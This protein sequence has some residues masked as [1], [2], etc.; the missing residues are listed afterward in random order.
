M[1]VNTEII[2]IF[3]I[4]V[5][6]G[7]VFVFIVGLMIELAKRKTTESSTRPSED[8]ARKDRRTRKGFPPSS[9]SFERDTSEPS[10]V[11]T[12]VV[13]LTWVPTPTEHCVCP[14]CR[15]ENGVSDPFCDICGR[16][17]NRRFE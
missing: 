4:L 2:S 5:I 7:V 9:S 11:D 13:F 15:A 8:L 12:A 16:S 3:V 14:L 6:L 10:P 17:L 1:Q